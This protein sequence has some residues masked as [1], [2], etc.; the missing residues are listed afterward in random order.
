M[1]YFNSYYFCDMY[2]FMKSYLNLSRDS[3]AG[4]TK[5]SI[6]SNWRVCVGL[7]GEACLNPIDF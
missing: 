4:E 5:E 1:G 3:F 6:N 7:P 2:A